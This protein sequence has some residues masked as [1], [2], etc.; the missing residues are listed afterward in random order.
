M[1]TLLIVE[2]PA[3]C[4]KIESY[5]GSDY[6]CVASFGHLREL[7]A[8]SDIVLSETEWKFILRE[9]VH[10]QDDSLFTAD[11]VLA[12]F[13]RAKKYP[14]SALQTLVTTIE[15]IEKIDNFT[16]KITTKKPSPTL[17]AQ[18]TNLFILPRSLAEDI[19]KKQIGT[20]PYRLLERNKEQILL[21]KFEN[22]W[23][24][25]QK[26]PNNL[27]LHKVGN[28]YGRLGEL[29]AKKT[30]VL[31]DVP[32]LFIEQIKN[33]KFA[34][35]VRLPGVKS[36]FLLF[37]LKNPFLKNKENRK[38]LS[39]ALDRT[40]MLGLAGE[41]SRLTS[42]FVGSGIF[43]FN[44]KIQ[45]PNYDFKK[46]KK[47]LELSENNILTLN[48]T[49]ENNKLGQFLKDELEKLN[50]GI[51]LN[52]IS[53]K[54][55]INNL[56]NSIGEMYL[57]GWDFFDGTIDNF[58]KEVAHSKEK[59]YG[60]LNGLNYKNN[61]VDRKIQVSLEELNDVKRLNKMQT[62]MNIITQSDPIGLPLFVI[63]NVFAITSDTYPITMRPD[64]VIYFEM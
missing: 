4:K 48:L 24:K 17:L 44:P 47:T 14:N 58:Y 9:G 32:P 27:T 29:R 45:L 50:L 6:K 28:K 61:L 56:Q 10:F 37:N 25:D 23:H 20:G 62:V 13:E 54:D 19:T 7:K 43:G 59:N 41:T 12:S 39:S 15:S 42:Q 11:D 18:L 34:K 51:K 38:I 57:V 60:S 53:D 5:L 1:T 21:T 33:E 52:E 36:I 8:L 3:K 46:A 63:D 30:D 49:Q 26:L 2:S 31:I 55:L 22:Y 64:G 16:L 35:I 40:K